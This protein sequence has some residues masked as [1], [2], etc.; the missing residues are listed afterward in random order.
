MSAC[1]LPHCK[2]KEL[3]ASHALSLISMFCGL[4]GRG[5]LDG[6]EKASVASLAGHFT[7]VGSSAWLSCQTIMSFGDHMYHCLTFHAAGI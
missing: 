4:Q 7:E 2:G 6:A 1:R 3:S 5:V